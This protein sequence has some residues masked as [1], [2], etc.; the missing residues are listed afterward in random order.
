MASA[1]EAAVARGM[2]EI[3][4][5]DH[6][7]F[8]PVD[9]PDYFRPVGYLSEISECR[10][11]YGD[12][13]AIRAAVEI[14]EPHLYARQAA[15]VL[16]AGDFDYVLGSAHYTD[17]MEAIFLAPFLNQE[18]PDFEGYFRQ[19]AGV[20]ATGDFDVLAHI[21]L[22]KRYAPK[23]TSGFGRSSPYHDSI[24]SALMSIVE[25]G[26]G[27]EINTSP[28]RMGHSEP[29]PSLDILRWYHELGG[30]MVTLGSDAHAPCD[31][32]SDLVAACAM[33]EA[34]G[35]SRLATYERRQVR[36]LRI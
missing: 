15:S 8:G 5:T 28:I 21:D 33:A 26:I 9:P 7:D 12:R 2:T 23:S 17:T 27:L 36:W 16:A 13:L 29:C 25:R 1:C 18:E 30:E 20:A 35:F 31:V 14:G 4:F 6:V 11:R 34:A 32:G 24:R 19:V 10:A 3:A 22:V